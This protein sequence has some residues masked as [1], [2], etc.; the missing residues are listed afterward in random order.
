M[1][2][3]KRGNVEL[4]EISIGARPEFD[5]LWEDDPNKDLPR[6]PDDPNRLM[7]FIRQFGQG[8]S[9]D[10]VDEA[11]GA[12]LQNLGPSG[13]QGLEAVQRTLSGEEVT[14]EERL[15]RQTAAASLGYRDFQEAGQE[16]SNRDREANPFTSIAGNVAGGLAAGFTGAGRVGSLGATP[17][18]TA[19]SARRGSQTLAQAGGTT[20]YGTEILRR[21]PAGFA[22]GA[23]Q[24]TITGLGG[25]QGNL[26]T[27]EGREA[28]VEDARRGGIIGGGFG[29]VAGIAGGAA[30]A[31]L[32]RARN[33]NAGMPSTTEDVPG[34]LL[35]NTPAQTAERLQTATRRIDD[36]LLHD[37]TLENTDVPPEFFLQIRRLADRT[38]SNL[39]SGVQPRL[40]RIAK[41]IGIAN[42]DGFYSFA[43]LRSYMDELDELA[44]NGSTE[45]QRLRSELDNVYRDAIQ[46]SRRDATVAIRNVN[47]QRQRMIDNVNRDNVNSLVNTQSNPN[48]QAINEAAN[49]ALED[50]GN[51]AEGLTR[52]LQNQQVKQNLQRY[53]EAFQREMSTRQGST[54]F[55]VSELMQ[56]YA[57]LVLTDLPLAF[58]DIEMFKPWIARFFSYLVPPTLLNPQVQGMAIGQVRTE[59]REPEPMIDETEIIIMPQ[60]EMSQSPEELEAQEIEAELARRREIRE[61]EQELQRRRGQGRRS[62][63]SERRRQRR[64]Q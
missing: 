15:A 58:R 44:R 8:V 54:P 42:E 5:K 26:D 60:E 12:V 9:G 19:A 53:A 47:N 23:T 55:G 57:G 24:G 33:T 62:L 63:R 32:N 3:P 2:N 21:L 39:G 43:Q 13:R 56:R 52:I 30:N 59:P 46:V 61:I 18:R 16:I 29:I 45:A 20:S 17:L 28:L 4:G 37:P 48:I 10:F 51:Q 1:S 7:T 36:Q 27:E 14:P 50:F 6:Q 41:N 34:E 35:G 49:N 25:S 38:L 40:K 11:A 22:V 64:A 31:Y